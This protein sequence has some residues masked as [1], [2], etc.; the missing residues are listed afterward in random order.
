MADQTPSSEDSPRLSRPTPCP[1]C[2]S[3]KGFRRVGK[4]RAQCTNCNALVKNSEINLEN[5][6]PQ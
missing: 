1:E 5:Q 2:S 6:E 4:F 3:T